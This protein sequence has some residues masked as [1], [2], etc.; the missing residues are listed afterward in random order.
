MEKLGHCGKRS[1]KSC[2]LYGSCMNHFVF[3]LWWNLRAL[4]NWLRNNTN[5]CSKQFVMTTSRSNIVSGTYG[6]FS[7]ES[8]T[9][10]KQTLPVFFVFRKKFV[11]FPCHLM[12]CLEIS[13]IRRF[14]PFSSFQTFCPGFFFY[15]LRNHKLTAGVFF[16]FGWEKITLGTNLKESA[17]LRMTEL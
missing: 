16:S 10:K 17:G 3:H 6:I 12:F 8:R 2:L 7:P 11:K 1:A 9:S 15:V 14:G 13:R 4:E 5:E